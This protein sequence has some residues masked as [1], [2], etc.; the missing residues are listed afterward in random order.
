L[1]LPAL[2]LAQGRVVLVYSSEAE[3]YTAALEG[4]RTA[5]REAAPVAVINL[6]DP[7][8]AAA[9]APALAPG[10]ARLIVVMGS[11]ARTAVAVLH[12]AAPV[13]ESMTLRSE[14]ESREGLAGSVR[15][16]LP[17][18]AILTE[19]RKVFPGRTRIAII[20]NASQPKQVDSAAAARARQQG[21]AL[22]IVDS[23][24]PDDLVRT[25]RS[26]K[27]DADF[28]VCLPDSTLYNSATVKPLIL[29]SLESRIPIVGFSSN[30]VRA[31][32]AA[33]VYPDFH[34][35]GAQTGEL[36]LKQLSGASVS[37]E[38]PRKLQIAVN[39]RV[40]RL[41]GLDFQTPRDGNV[42]VIR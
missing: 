12:P 22:R 17:L 11:E 26:V 7:A 19:L 29:A 40:L 39:P 28:V 3:A 25:F 23:N 32:A 33:G 4:F 37:D 38:S 30:F 35:I 42:L 8:G 31:G 2:G 9:L 14:Q 15:L 1:L 21:F 13:I 24:G 20:R 34:D 16:D 5:L 36:A 41:L 10:N 27:G 6:R 18:P